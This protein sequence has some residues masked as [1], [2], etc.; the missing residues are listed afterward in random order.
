MA[1]M[2]AIEQATGER[3][4]TIIGYCLGGTLT[5]CLL[6]YMA[7]K[8]DDADQGRDLLHRDDWTSPSPASSRCSSTRSSSS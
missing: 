7:A 8:G 5:A 4:L 3:E 6:A 1:A 2:D